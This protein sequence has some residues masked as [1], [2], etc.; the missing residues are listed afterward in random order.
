MIS[1]EK[2]RGKRF[3]QRRSEESR[4]AA[5]NQGRGHQRND[6]RMAVDHLDDDHERRDRALR[7]RGEIADQPERDQHLQLHSRKHDVQR[8]A[9][10]RTDR[11]RRCEQATLCSGKLGQSPMSIM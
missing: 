5:G 11:Q 3:I 10:A 7:N 8:I 6:G 1:G 2:T 9:D 4:H